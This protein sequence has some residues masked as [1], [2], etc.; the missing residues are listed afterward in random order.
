MTKLWNLEPRVWFKWMVLFGVIGAVLFIIHLHL[1]APRTRSMDE[2]V[3]LF[4]PYISN[5]LSLGALAVSYGFFMVGAAKWI[6]LRLRHG[7]EKKSAR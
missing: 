3:D 5:V 6:I 2:P 7:S 1:A 4:G